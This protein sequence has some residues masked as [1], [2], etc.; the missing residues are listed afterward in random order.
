MHVTHS[1]ARPKAP[2]KKPNSAAV[3]EV[4]GSPHERVH[5]ATR[6][7]KQALEGLKQQA[8]RMMA[9]STRSLRALRVGDNVTVPVS[10]FDRSK[11]DPPNLVGVVMEASD[12]GYT[13]GTTSGIIQGKLARNQIEFVKYSKLQPTDIPQTRLSIR[14]IVQA[15]SVCR[16]QGYKRCHCRSKCLSTRCSCLKAGLRC[17][18][19]CHSFKTCDN[20]D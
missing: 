17:N 12:G 20:I 19:A 16:G 4:H 13:I 18:S 1:T 10:A 14:E 6:A 5:P 8:N 15:Q 7:R 9:R 3:E 2:T 11:G